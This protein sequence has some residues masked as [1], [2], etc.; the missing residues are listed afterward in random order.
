MRNARVSE[1]QNLTVLSCAGD[2]QMLSGSLQHLLFA[3]YAVAIGF[4]FDGYRALALGGGS[5]T[6]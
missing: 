4:K 6:R 3:I 2:P 1:L 5:E